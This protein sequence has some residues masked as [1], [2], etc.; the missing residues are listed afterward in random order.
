MY[1]SVFPQSSTGILLIL[2]ICTFQLFCIKALSGKWHIAR[3]DSVTAEVRDSVHAEGVFW[4]PGWILSNLG[5]LFLF[6]LFTSTVLIDSSFWERSSALFFIVWDFC[7]CGPSHPRFLHDE[8]GCTDFFFFPLLCPCLPWMALPYLGFQVTL[9]VLSDKNMYYSLSHGC[10]LFL[11]F[12]RVCHH[13]QK[14][15]WLI[16]SDKTK[17]NS[18][19]EE[20][21]RRLLPVS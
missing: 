12:R 6:I 11:W 4:T 18:S 8:E 2:D 10:S 15:F 21:A 16:N 9:Q 13:C 3:L 19:S 7:P 5:D 20:G 14:F 1:W 17:P